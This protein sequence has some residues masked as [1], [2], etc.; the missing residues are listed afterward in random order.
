M[1]SIYKLQSTATDKLYIGCTSRTL[2]KRFIDHLSHFNSPTPQKSM[3]HAYIQM[4]ND[5]LKMIDFT[6]KFITEV[7]DRKEAYA[8]EERTI[9]KYRKTVGVFN[10]NRAEVCWNKGTKGI[11]KSNSGSI[12]KGER[13]GI[14][15]EFKKGSTVGMKTRFKKGETNN[16]AGTVTVHKDNRNH[17]I[18]PDKLDS[19]LA[20][21]FI[22]G[23][24]PRKQARGYYERNGRFTAYL[25]IEGKLKNL[26]TYDTKEEA[27]EVRRK[28]ML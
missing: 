7:E 16:T 24:K 21:G 14:T 1:Y 28:A 22:K 6:I 19:Y 20:N 12:K 17:R 23:M 4:R 27:Q 8:L 13:R 5:G 18:S 10:C 25:T 3:I 11:C 26:G 15:T 2:N 9:K